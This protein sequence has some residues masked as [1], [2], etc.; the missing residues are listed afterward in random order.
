ML[1]KNVTSLCLKNM[2]KK[3]VKVL[4]RYLEAQCVPSVNLNFNTVLGEFGFVCRDLA[5]E[6]DPIAAIIHWDTEQFV[7]LPYKA[8]F[9]RCEM[10]NWK[11]TANGGTRSASVKGPRN[12]TFPIYPL[13]VEKYG[14]IGVQRLC[15]IIPSFDV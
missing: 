6:S 3:R 2:S 1:V 9:D 7:R 10:N 4:Q 11:I 12:L 5:S 13:F 8:E 14:E 15:I